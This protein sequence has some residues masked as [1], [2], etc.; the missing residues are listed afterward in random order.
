MTW[1]PR[2]GRA[3]MPILA[4][5][6]GGML[7]LWPAFLNGYPL[8]FSDT[9]AFLHQVAPP[10]SGPLAIWDKPYV[11]GPILLALSWRISLWPAVLAQ[12][13]ML[14]WLLWLIQRV[15]CGAARPGRHLVICLGAALLTTA[16]FTASLLMPDVFTPAVLLSLL[17]LGFAPA[18]R[19]WE[20][21]VLGLIAALGIAA[22]L[23]HL[24]LALTL[25]AYVTTLAGWRAA[26]RVALPL[27]AALGLLLA[28]NVWGHGR[29]SLSPYGATFLLARLQDDG[30][31]TAVIRA[32]C[33][34]SGWYL[35]GAVD[36]L[37]MDSDEF[38]WAPDS[39]LNQAPDGTPRPLG[40][41]ALASE[42]RAI[43]AETLRAA[44]LD[45]ARAMLRNTAHQLGLAAAG[46]TLGPGYLAVALRPRLVETVGAADLAAYDRA[47]QPRGRL[48]AMVAPMQVP[49]AAVLLL[50]LG[51]LILLAWAACGGAVP[52]RRGLLC[53]ALLGFLVNAWATGALS[54]PHHRYE[55]RL[56][57]LAPVLAA[58]AIWPAS[59]RVT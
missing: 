11:Y 35:C 54:K 9:A 40:G 17:L 8:V 44:P 23:S 33:P 14:S 48:L 19:H 56:I 49:H 21:A 58:L 37:P 57:W 46:D 29:F 52:A 34:G 55:A 26:V 15:L 28:G 7:F 22:H 41:V 36:R 43:V 50:S 31:A 42:A 30:P 45:V 10:P 59:R 47:L 38:L 25:L 20:R 27:L 53:G 12:G 5:F 32:R 1:R 24:P 18:L 13:L 4:L 39:P 51:V 3:D 16:P 6:L 2:A